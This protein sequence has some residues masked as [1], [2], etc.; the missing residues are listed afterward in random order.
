MQEEDERSAS[1]GPAARPPLVD[2]SGE[3]CR[4][5][6]IAAGT[7]RVYQGHPTTVSMPDGRTLLCVWC[8]EHGGHCGPVARST[9][10]GLTW[11]RVG[12]PAQWE[13]IYNC[14]S[15]YRFDGPDGKRRLAVFAARA[16]QDAT[17]QQAVSEDDGLHWSEFRSLSI[18]CEMAFTSVIRLTSGDWLGL[19]PI[20]SDALRPNAIEVW[21]SVSRDGGFT[22]EQPTLAC[23][24]PNRDPDEPGLVRSPDGGQLLCLLRENL[25]TG[26]SLMMTSDDEGRTWSALRET[27][28]GVSGDR[29]VARY[30]RDGRLVVCCRD[31]APGSPAKGCFVAWVGTYGDL[32]AGRP[33]QYR[34][35]LLHHY[36]TPGA[37]WTACDSG[38]PGLE[39]LPDGTFVATTYVKYGPGPEKNSVVSARFKLEETD[40]LV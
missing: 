22:W 1:T 3:T 2:L 17:M 36:P 16:E 24:D 21:Q 37:A 30:A 34:I 23:R 32:V 9:D 11:T 10:G 40:R 29:H 27:P 15:I 38:Y 13:H 4:Q 28:W 31:M 5:V 6:V 39:L 8:I 19:Y 12:T 7:E 35:K 33:G 18:P 20:R 25:R 26:H 14:P